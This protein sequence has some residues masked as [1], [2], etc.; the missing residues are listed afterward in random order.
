MKTRG[1]KGVFAIKNEFLNF[2]F[3]SKIVDISPLRGLPLLS[4]A[5]LNGCKT[6][7]QLKLCHS[8]LDSL[9]W[10]DKVTGLETLEINGYA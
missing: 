5:G 3:T 2:A 1:S 4:A 6:I 10:P 7:H 8:P 9:S